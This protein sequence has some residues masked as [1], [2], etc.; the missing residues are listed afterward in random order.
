MKNR[1]SYLN[2]L[3]EDS[4]NRELLRWHNRIGDLLVQVSL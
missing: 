3:R 2:S 4:V 1:L